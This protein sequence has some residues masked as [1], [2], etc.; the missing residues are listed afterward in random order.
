MFWEILRIWDFQFKMMT[1][2]LIWHMF[3]DPTLSAKITAVE[4]IKKKGRELTANCSQPKTTAADEKKHKTDCADTKHP[5]P[6]TLPCFV[7][8]DKVR[9]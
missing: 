1:T 8:R 3:A 4:A 5:A 2:K 9:A 6:F 7:K